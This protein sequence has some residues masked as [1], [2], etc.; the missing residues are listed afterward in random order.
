M[1]RHSEDKRVKLGAEA[2]TPG[3]ERQAE[4][5]E[6]G[7]LVQ[8]PEKI[9]G[10]PGVRYAVWV[11]HAQRHHP[12]PK[13]QGTFA[14]FYPKHLVRRT[15]SL[16]CMRHHTCMC[17]MLVCLLLSG[18][19]RGLRT[20]SRRANAAVTAASENAVLA[21]D[22]LPFSAAFLLALLAFDGPDTAACVICIYR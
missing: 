8:L 12:R 3:E 6:D 17:S 10:Q 9:H 18:V 15:K 2:Y 16:S 11:E 21:A 22:A 4:L 14:R 5:R 13:A 20:C 19:L 7:A 1:Y